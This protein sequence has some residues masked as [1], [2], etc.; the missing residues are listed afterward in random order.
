MS[1][2][3]DGSLTSQYKLLH[4]LSKRTVHGKWKKIFAGWNCRNLVCWSEL[5][6]CILHIFTLYLMYDFVLHMTATSSGHWLIYR[7]PDLSLHN[8]SVQ[9][10][11]NYNKQSFIYSSDHSKDKNIFSLKKEKMYTCCRV[12]GEIQYAVP[13]PVKRSVKNWISSVSFF[14]QA[15]TA[16]KL[17]LQHWKL[18]NYRI[19]TCPESSFHETSL[20]HCCA[21]H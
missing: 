15:H 2:G 1:A 16:E 20:T 5:L 19:S 10:Q 9:I 11:Q 6:S 18:S 3:C 12:A 7:W 8:V 17:Q 14:L 13:S 21:Q 4:S